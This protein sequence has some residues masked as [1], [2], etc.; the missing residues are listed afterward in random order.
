MK[1]PKKL[2]SSKKSVHIN[3]EKE[4]HAGM[5]S[6]LFNADLTMQD[7]FAAC[8]HRL[9]SEDNR[10]IRMLDE[11]KEDKQNKTLE[12]ISADDIE[13]IFDILESESP[14]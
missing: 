2:L 9:A 10:F 6:I 7:F 5:R 11:I 8:A 14:V 12:K 4:T 1:D 13:R 3:L